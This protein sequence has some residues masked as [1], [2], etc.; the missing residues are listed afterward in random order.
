MTA[1]TSIIFFSVISLTVPTKSIANQHKAVVFMHGIFGK[2]TES[3]MI[4]AFLKEVHPDTPFYS[5]ALYQRI[6]SLAPLWKQV[7]IIRKEVEGIMN[8]HS[9]GIHLI[10]FSQG[11]LICRG[12]LSTT[13][14]NVDTFISLS[15]PLAG[16]YGDTSY[17]K[18]LF[19][20]FLKSEIYKVFYSKTGQDLSI[21]NYWKDPHHLELY[22]KHSNFLAPL[23]NDTYTSEIND[24]KKNFLRLSRIV[25][26]GGPDDGVITPWESSHFAFY[27]SNEK[28]VEFNQQRYFTEDSFGL[29]TLFNEGKI[30]IY[31]IPGVQHIHWHSNRTVF[32]SAIL[33]WLI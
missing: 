31:V 7:D 19:P 21:G 10:C 1:V 20:N 25:L 5:I 12:I 23:N 3:R 27:D 16:Q 28:V 14:H 26:I 2:S 15:S 11:G 6:K 22:Q 9:D 17:L 29:K 33:P 8:N 24:Y 4:E 32:N 30:K 18:Y 13:Q